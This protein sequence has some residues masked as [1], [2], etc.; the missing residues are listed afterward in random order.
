MRHR[1]LYSLPAAIVIVGSAALVAVIILGIRTVLGLKPRE[2]A[3][4]VDS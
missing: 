2:D 1:L 3:A 4:A